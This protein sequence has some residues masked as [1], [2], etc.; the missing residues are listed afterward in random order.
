MLKK[1]TSLL[2]TAALA[3]TGASAFAAGSGF[4]L[5]AGLSYSHIEMG[6]LPSYYFQTFNGVGAGFRLGYDFKLGNATF[7]RYMVGVELSTHYLGTLEQ[8]N[9]GVTAVNLLATGTVAFNEQL[10]LVAK[11]GFTR[12]I[13]SGG[14]DDNIARSDFSPTA[15]VALVYNFNSNWDI[16][17][18]YNHIFGSSLSSIY[19]RDSNSAIT[20][21]TFMLGATYHFGSF[22]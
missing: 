15:A 6:S 7:N 22:S 12:E 8:T 4:Y 3:T 18:Q 19:L 2:L 5:G 21:D 20:F 11:A 16:N 17:F 13:I 14:D 10:S 1:T 9:D